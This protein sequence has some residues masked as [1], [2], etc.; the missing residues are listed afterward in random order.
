[1]A[2]IEGISLLDDYKAVPLMAPTELISTA[3]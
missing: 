2:S 3:W 1:M